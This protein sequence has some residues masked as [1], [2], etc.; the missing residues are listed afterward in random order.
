MN[1]DL[2]E[3]MVL[4][5]GL[6]ILAVIVDGLRRMQKSRKNTV[7]LSK[8]ASKWNFADNSDEVKN[9]ELL[10][11]NTRVI[12]R[13]EMEHALQ[14]QYDNSPAP[15]LMTPVRSFETVDEM[16]E[17]EPTQEEM[18]LETAIQLEPESISEA[19]AEA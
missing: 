6:L 10:G 4:I 2:R 16:S 14:Q 5:G 15:I 19:E 8:R 3:W 1:L 17:P 7:K 13:E 12:E 9:S 18:V 11:G